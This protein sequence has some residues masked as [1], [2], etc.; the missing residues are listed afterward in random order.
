MHSEQTITKIFLGLLCPVLLL[1]AGC[2][3]LRSDLLDKKEAEP[4]LGSVNSKV[5]TANT[6]FGFNLFHEIRKTEQNKNIFISPFSV[7][8]AL[9]MTLNGAAG[10]TEQAMTD[11]L[12]LQGLNSESMNTGYAQLGQALQ[13][14]DPKV[15]L[16]I[17]NSLW[18]RQGIPFKA[19]FL[20]RNTQFFGAEISTLDFSDPSASKTINQWVDTH[21]H[22]KIKK[23]VG[24]GIDPDTVLFLI[25]AIYFKGT[26]QTKFDS[27]QTR[28][29]PFHLATGSQK[30]TAMMSRT[31]DYPYYE[32]YDEHFQ[33]IRLPYGN[34]R[35]SMYIFLPGRESN[36]D[37]FLE[38]LTPERWEQW[39]PQFYKQEVDLAMPKF[40]L[41]YKKQLND[42]LKALGM[43]I[44]FNPGGADFSRMAPLEELEG[45]LYIGEVLHEAVV[46]VNEEGTEAAAATKVEIKVLIWSAP[47]MFIVDRPFFFAIRDN[48]TK[49]VLFMGVVVEP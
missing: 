1:F 22:S 34:G 7:S 2:D 43:D 33:A 18:A 3:E 17:A 5:V 41:K 9:A 31:G 29:G 8:F 14:S 39:M 19:D 37:T 21:T 16:S 4:E 10:E 25:N 46:E 28:D 44:A 42:P 23:I 49:T 45:N 26:W 38:R 30:Q 27:S 40:K 24:D 6:K 12:Q 35:M 15:T 32:N 47:P 20:Q 48:E 11:T 36:L 13:T